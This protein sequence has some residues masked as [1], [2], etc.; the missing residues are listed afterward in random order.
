MSLSSQ[1]M[2]FDT[3]SLVRLYAMCWLLKDCILHFLLCQRINC[4]KVLDRLI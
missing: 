1:H 4:L 3:N 2:C